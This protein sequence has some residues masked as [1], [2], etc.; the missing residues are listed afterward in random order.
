MSANQTSYLAN[1][2]YRRQWGL[3]APHDAVTVRWQTIRGRETDDTGQPVVDEILTSQVHVEMM[4]ESNCWADICGLRV[5][6]RAMR[7][8]GQREPRLVI[9]ASPESCH[10]APSPTA[11]AGGA[12]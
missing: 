5:W 6:I 11:G 4:D 10:E 12:R 1:D 3:K 2:D 7:V 8:T 9:T